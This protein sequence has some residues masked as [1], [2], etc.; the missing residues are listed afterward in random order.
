[1]KRQRDVALLAKIGRR[2]EKAIMVS[3]KFILARGDT[4]CQAFAVSFASH[5]PATLL[6]GRILG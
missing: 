3:G 2:F 6:I 4:W 5:I 1:M